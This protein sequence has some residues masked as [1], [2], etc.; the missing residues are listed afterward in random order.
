MCVAVEFVVDRGWR[1]IGATSCVPAALVDLKVCLLSWLVIWA[2]TALTTLIQT[3]R[4]TM[5][6]RAMPGVAMVPPPSLSVK[7]RFQA[8]VTRLG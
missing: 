5:L 6:S 4:W 8:V 3:Y 2:A 7:Y 1:L